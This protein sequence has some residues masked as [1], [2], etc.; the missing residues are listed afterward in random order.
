MSL[1]RPACR[2]TNCAD[3][4]NMPPEP[5]QWSYTRPWY[6]LNNSTNIRTTHAWVKN[7]PPP[8]CPPARR[9]A[10]GS[11]HR[12]ALVFLEKS[13]FAVL[14]RSILVVENTPCRNE[15]L[16]VEDPLFIFFAKRPYVWYSNFSFYMWWYR[17]R[18][19][20]DPAPQSQPR[21]LPHP[22][23]AGEVDR[24]AVRQDAETR[25]SIFQRN[26]S[27]VVKNKNCLKKQIICVMESI[28]SGEIPQA[29]FRGIE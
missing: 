15:A 3:W 4:T 27:Q 6:G 16:Q 24:K 9:T 25:G 22:A 7:S 19:F 29:Y 2:S 14:R 12:C 5:Q 23:R 10:L 26:K 17:R 21:P 20:Q 1:V 11:I 28:T 8:S 18:L 13:F